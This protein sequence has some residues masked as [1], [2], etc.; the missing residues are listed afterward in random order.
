MPE[1]KEQKLGGSKMKTKWLIYNKKKPHWI[2]FNE[3]SNFYYK[4]ILIIY[5]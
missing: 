1:L 5:I 3:Q 4:H 2:G